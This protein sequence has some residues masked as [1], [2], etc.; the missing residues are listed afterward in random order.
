MHKWAG[1]CVS[2]FLSISKVES[3]SGKWKVFTLGYTIANFAM[4]L[5]FLFL[6][7]VSALSCSNKPGVEW[8]FKTQA[9]LSTSPAI[10]GNK[11]IISG[12]DHYLYALDL[13]T[14]EVIWKTDLGDRIMT[15]PLAEENNIYVG[16]ASGYFYQINAGNGNPGWKFQA[17]GMIEYEPCADADGIY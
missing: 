17:K 5:L 14:G 1:F 4:R 13:K 11:L 2:G 12:S 10:S 16:T 6:L 9:P 3:E 7:C 8:K 15:K